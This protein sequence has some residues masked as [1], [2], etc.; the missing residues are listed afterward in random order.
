MLP[1]LKNSR[2]QIHGHR[3]CRGLFPENT[4]PA[5]LHALQLGV[6]VLEMDVVLSADKQVVVAHEPWL[7]AKLGLAADGRPIDPQTEQTHNLYELPYATIRQSVVGVF[8]HPTFPGQQQVATYRPLLKEVINAAELFCQQAGRPPV[9]Y[10]IEIKSSPETEDR[11]HP[12]PGEFTAMVLAALPKAVLPRVTLLSF[13]SRVLQA[14][15]QLL[16]A[17]RVCLLVETPFSPASVF[18]SLGFVPDVFGPDYTLLQESVF[19]ELQH[20]Y[21]GIEVVPWTI[22]EPAEMTRFAAMPVTGITTDFPNYALQVL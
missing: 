9:G 2:P 7:S 8:P 5:F 11:F 1:S 6:D 19:T 21:K 16:P 10:S 3:G 15:R 13:D 17:S 18:D 20:L 14:A 12:A 4:L 22:N